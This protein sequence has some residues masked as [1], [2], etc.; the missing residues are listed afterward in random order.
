MCKMHQALCTNWKNEHIQ[1]L[2]IDAWYVFCDKVYA[3]VTMQSSTVSSLI[4]LSVLSYFFN[5]NWKK[6]CPSPR[7][8]GQFSA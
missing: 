2:F 4:D 8:I 1:L 7:I 3:V 6:S 5:L